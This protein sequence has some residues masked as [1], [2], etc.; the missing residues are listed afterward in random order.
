[1]HKKIVNHK[2]IRYV[3]EEYQSYH[4]FLDVQDSRKLNFR[5]SSRDS[6]G[7][8]NARKLLLNGTNIGLYAVKEKVQLQSK[9]NKTIMTA[10]R[11]D[12]V[13][14]VPNVPNAVL[15]LPKSMINVKKET[16]KNKVIELIINVEFSGD[17][18]ESSII[19]WGSELLAKIINLEKNGKRVRLYYMNSHSDRDWED[20]YYLKILMKNERQP[21]DIKRILYPM[22]AK[23][24]Q[25]NHVYDWYERLP[26]VKRRDYGVPLNY[27]TN[28]EIKERL[29]PLETK[30]SYVLIFGEN[31]D[32]AF[33]RFNL[34]GG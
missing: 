11:N 32:E 26:E 13:G 22:T 17:T 10:F 24:M 15:N 21:L 7:Y 9:V 18:S 2:S 34:I 31:L 19:E 25:T 8:T 27:Y 3:I 23:T 20:M 12:I 33:K 6:R 4:E 30:N 29:E 28:S 14:F 16:V 1:M 5:Y